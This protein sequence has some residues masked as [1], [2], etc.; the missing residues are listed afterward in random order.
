MS[1][2]SVAAFARS[3]SGV[4][5]GNTL[6][7]TGRRHGEKRNLKEE[8]E[9]RIQKVIVDKTPDQLALPMPR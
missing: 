1:P 7:G 3:M 4:V 6:G 9:R 5:K 2:S 8:R